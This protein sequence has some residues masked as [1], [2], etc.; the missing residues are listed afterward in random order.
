MIMTLI[1][2]LAEDY[3]FENEILLHSERI[4]VIYI[5]CL[6]YYFIELFI[7]MMSDFILS[8]MGDLLGF[9]GQKALISQKD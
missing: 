6:G 5:L 4:L 2:L 3:D 9:W 8:F 7:W 1:T